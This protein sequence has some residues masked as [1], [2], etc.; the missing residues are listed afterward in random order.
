MEAYLINVGISLLKTVPFLIITFI[1]S[2]LAVYYVEKIRLSDL[3]KDM[4]PKGSEKFRQC[5]DF[6]KGAVK[7]INVV[8]GLL[9]VGAV[10][11]ALTSTANTW[12][13][14]TFDRSQSAK[15]IQQIQLNQ[16]SSPVVDRTKQPSLNEEQR[17]ERFDSIVDYKSRIAQE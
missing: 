12:K 10:A 14:E 8:W 15:A 2:R 11:M 17:A 9:L 5:Q 16:P 13:N 6:Y 3:H 4:T 7:V 1:M